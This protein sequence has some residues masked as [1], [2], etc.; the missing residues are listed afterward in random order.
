MPAVSPAAKHGSNAGRD[1]QRKDIA[2]G[3]TRMV[4]G[5]SVFRYEQSYFRRS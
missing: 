5:S 4:D 2:S 1:P 3:I